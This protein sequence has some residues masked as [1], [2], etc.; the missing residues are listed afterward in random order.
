MLRRLAIG[1]HLVALREPMRRTLP[2]STGSRLGDERPLPWM[3]RTQR[4]PQLRAALKKVG[5][6][7]ARFVTRVSRC[8]SS[9]P[10]TDQCPRRSR[11]EHVAAEALAQE[12]L[13]GFVF[14]PDVPVA[15]AKA[16]RHAGLRAARRLRRPG[17]ARA[18]SAGAGAARAARLPAR[19]GATSA[20]TARRSTSAG[21]VRGVAAP[22]RGPGAGACGRFFAFAEER[23]E[24]GELGHG[25]APLQASASR[26]ASASSAAMQPVPALVTAW[27]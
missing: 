16:R 22:P 21:S 2:F 9:S 17:A 14:L 25:R 23:L 7:S 12:S 26:Y 19:N 27:R 4:Q 5:E 6:R 11:D 15:P 18:G 13:L 10:C 8:R 3:T 1:Q 20:N 24:L